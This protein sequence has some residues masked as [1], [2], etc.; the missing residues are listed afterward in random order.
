MVLEREERKVAQ[1]MKVPNGRCGSCRKCCREENGFSVIALALWWL[2]F[3][4]CPLGKK[5]S[6]DTCLPP[7]T[8]ELWLWW[9]EQPALS[10]AHAR[11]SPGL[12]DKKPCLWG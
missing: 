8:P 9:E 11:L 7:A 2:P 3:L 12:R 6:P 10:Q 1:W 5:T 4:G